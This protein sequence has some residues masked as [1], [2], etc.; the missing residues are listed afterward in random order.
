MVVGTMGIR[1]EVSTPT[2]TIPNP[3]D[4]ALTQGLSLHIAQRRSTRCYIHRADGVDTLSR[5]HQKENERLDIAHK[6]FEVRL[7]GRLHLAPI[8]P[9]PQ[10]ILDLGTGTGINLTRGAFAHVFIPCLLSLDLL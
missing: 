6:L 7:N 4:E 9:N 2:R 5:A 3:N 1:R 8:G 10:R